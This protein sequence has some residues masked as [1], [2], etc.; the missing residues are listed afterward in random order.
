M[1]SPW[2]TKAFLETVRVLVV[3]AGGLGCEILKDLAYS[4]FK[5]IDVVDMDTIDVTNLNRQFLF[6]KKDVGAYKSKVAAEFVMARCPAVTI[7]HYT[8]AIQDFPEDLGVFGV[9]I[10]GLDNMEARRYLNDSLCNRVEVDESGEP[11]DPS[12]IIP[13][14][15]GGTTGFIGQCRV[16]I[17]R[18]TACMTCVRGEATKQ[19]TFQLCTIAA[20]P[21]RP[22]HCV[23][24]AMLMQWPEAFPGR[25]YDTDSPDDMRWLYE[26]ALARAKEFGIDGVTYAQT[27]GVVKNIIP[28]IGSTN[29]I[30]AA[31]CVN[32]ALKAMSYCSQL[33][34]TVWR[35]V[36]A[37]GVSGAIDESSRR[38]DCPACGPYESRTYSVS[39]EFTLGALLNK[40]KRDPKVFLKDPT[41]GTSSGT[42]LWQRMFAGTLGKTLTQPLKSLMSVGDSLDV[43]EKGTL[44]QTMRVVVSFDGDEAGSYMPG[45]EAAIEEVTWEVDE[46]ATLAGIINRCKATPEKGGLSASDPVLLQPGKAA[47]S[48]HTDDEQLRREARQSLQEGQRVRVSD[49]AL[50]RDVY[51]LLEYDGDWM[52]GDV[53]AP[54]RAA[55]GAGGAAGST[56]GR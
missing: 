45:D 33:C 3:G 17:P 8:C 44:K 25:K 49:S 55:G 28:A 46:R 4:G 5:E 24:Y 37:H 52:D 42:V 12:Q 51:L 32:E 26:K 10:G 29:A 14:I 40:L 43:N 13:F 11:V 9:V 21:R 7:R 56:S 35:F 31:A 22:E 34:S 54:G 50:A 2:Q 6:R 41:V 18:V 38:K 30:V 27:M 1:A 15:D 48:L 23:G 20:T 16:I 36:G 39:P 19:R 47:L 53:A